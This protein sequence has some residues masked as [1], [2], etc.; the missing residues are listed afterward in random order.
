MSTI[1]D[2][3]LRANV[4]V[5]TVSRVIN[6]NGYVHKDTKETI[7]KAI[8]DLNYFPN[9]QNNEFDD[10][11]KKTIGIIINTIPSTTAS[12]LIDSIQQQCKENGY[13]TL[14]GITRNSQSLEKFY[15]DL[16]IK[17]DVD[18]IIL[19]EEINS[20]VDFIS[21]KKPMVSIDFKINDNIP[22]IKINNS[23]AVTNAAQELI[24]NNCKN[25]LLVK[26]TNDDI[27]KYKNFVETIKLN[28]I[29]LTSLNVDT[30]INKLSLYDFLKN[31]NFDGIYTT[32]DLIAIPV[33]SILQQLK[34]NIPK[35]CCMIG[36]DNSPFSTL[37]FPALTSIDY[38]VEKIG[39]SAV[40]TLDSIINHEDINDKIITT[41]LIKRESTKREILL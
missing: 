33:T 41:E 30:N 8:E 13:K 31:S 15:L 32:S 12:K 17:Y 22:S 34:I 6:N 39:E 5:T 38:P 2:V 9:N 10:H 20:I 4:S 37:I 16:F 26:Y 28:N 21:L 27:N 23:L 29:K 36:Y 35:E 11:S 18:G 1:K 25:V 19:T 3:A 14:L 7:T 24:D 40:N